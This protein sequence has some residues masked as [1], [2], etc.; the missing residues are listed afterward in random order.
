MPARSRSGSDASTKG[1]A[2]APLKMDAWM[3][4]SSKHRSPSSKAASP[5]HLTSEILPF[6]EQRAASLFDQNFGE[7]LRREVPRR[8]VPPLQRRAKAQEPPLLGGLR[9][10]GPRRAPPRG[11]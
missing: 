7:L 10:G 3:G 11:G 6:Y 4:V 2:S 8:P 9:P 5:L 1:D